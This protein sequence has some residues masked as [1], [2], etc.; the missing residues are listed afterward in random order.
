MI[1]FSADAQP[2]GLCYESGF[3]YKTWLFLAWYQVNI[4]KKV[5]ADFGLGVLWNADLN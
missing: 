1:A 3:S 5:F 4:K 2:A